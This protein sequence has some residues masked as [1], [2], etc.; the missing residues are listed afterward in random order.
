MDPTSASARGLELV[1]NLRRTQLL[2]PMR[3]SGGTAAALLEELHHMRR[4]DVEQPVRESLVD[5]LRVFS[6]ADARDPS[7]AF[8]QFG[9]CSN[10]EIDHIN[11]HQIFA[12]GKASGVV[13]VGWRLPLSSKSRATHWISATKLD[14]LYENE[15]GLTMYYS[16]GAPCILFDNLSTTKCCCNGTRGNMGSLWFTDGLV[17]EN[18]A[19]ALAAGGYQYVDISDNPPLTITMFPVLPAGDDGAGIDSLTEGVVE[20][21]VGLAKTAQKDYRCGSLFAAAVG[22][23]KLLAHRRHPVGLAFAL[24]AYKLQGGTFGRF[25]ASVAPKPFWPAL[26]ME[27]FYVFYSRVRELTGFRILSKPSAKDGGLSNLLALTHDPELRVWHEGYDLVTGDWDPV[28]ARAVAARLDAGVAKG[29]PPKPA[30]KRKPTLQDAVV[31][32]AKAAALERFG[33][34]GGVAAQPVAVPKLVANLATN[35]SGLPSS[36]PQIEGP[37][38]AHARARVE[39][40]RL[41][42]LANVRVTVTVPG[43]PVAVAL[44][45]GLAVSQWNAAFAQGGNVARLRFVGELQTLFAA[46]AAQFPGRVLFGTVSGAAASETCFQVW[47]ANNKNWDLPNGTPILGGGQ[48]AVMGVQKLGVFGIVTTPLAGVPAAVSGVGVTAVLAAA[49]A[50]AP[51]ADA[52][53]RRAALAALTIPVLKAQLRTAGLP[54][55]GN[56]NILINS[57]MG[58]SVASASAIGWAP[59]K[60]KVAFDVPISPAKRIRLGS[61]NVWPQ[62][63][64]G[65]VPRMLSC[66][67]SNPYDSVLTK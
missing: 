52:V 44:G 37:F 20:V 33:V 65:A 17:P 43:C 57:L 21:A 3:Q 27:S 66:L 67:Q 11:K 61:E 59:S 63:S 32:K 53:A 60:Q 31:K 55:S 58:A 10:A 23:P 8:P 46:L 14:E 40:L 48:A 19:A 51:S 4:L 54:V 22:I 25:V 5:K 50:A 7:W 41:M 36:A 38:V 64:A 1:R 24:S 30:P 35:Q 34:A 42:M 6:K 13:V 56:K 29:P 18:L 28:R 49:H 9:A 39:E 26:D 62:T 12:Y 47:G 15:T 2:Q 16:P 45:T